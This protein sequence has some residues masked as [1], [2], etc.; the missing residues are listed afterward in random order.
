[1]QVVVEAV[2]ACRLRLNLH[3]FAGMSVW[4][5]AEGGGTILP[6]DH[7]AAGRVQVDLPPGL[8]DLEIRLGRT[9]VRRRA[10]SL[11]LLAWLLLPAVAVATAVRAR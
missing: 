6:H 11:A 3:D 4:R 1:M 5:A 10:D 2:T 8:H 7:D 9:P